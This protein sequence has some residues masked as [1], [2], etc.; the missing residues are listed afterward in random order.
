MN[1]LFFVSIDGKYVGSIWFWDDQTI[2]FF[3]KIK[4]ED[5]PVKTTAHVKRC[6]DNVLKEG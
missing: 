1:V 5:I 4:E 6:I 3:D 2:T